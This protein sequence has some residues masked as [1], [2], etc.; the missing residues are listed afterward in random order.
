M[1][2]YVCKHS[3]AIR[4]TAYEEEATGQAEF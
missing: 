1:E 4:N 3:P 2:R